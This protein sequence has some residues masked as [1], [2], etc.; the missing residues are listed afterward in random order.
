M[1]IRLKLA[2][3]ET[4]TWRR[5]ARLRSRGVYDDLSGTVVAEA[6]SSPLARAL[7]AVEPRRLGLGGI[8]PARARF[9]EPSTGAHSPRRD[10]PR[11]RGVYR[12]G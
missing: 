7:R 6:G 8:I 1:L 9:T 12:P 2:E 3:A 10:H 4:G 11:S 5:P